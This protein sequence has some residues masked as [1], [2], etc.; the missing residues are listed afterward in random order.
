[1]P[2]ARRLRAGPDAAGRAHA[3]DRRRRALGGRRRRRGRSLVTEPG[4]QGVGHARRAVDDVAP[5]ARRSAGDQRRTGQHR[6]DP[7]AG[8]PATRGP[9]PVASCV[10]PLRPP[11]LSGRS[12]PDQ[13]PPAADPARRGGGRRRRAGWPTQAGHRQEQGDQH[14][15][16]H[17]HDDRPPAP[18]AVGLAGIEPATSSLSGMRSNRLSYS[19]AVVRSSRRSERHPTTRPMARAPDAASQ[20]STA[21]PGPAHLRGGAAGRRVS[22]STT[23]SRMPPTRSL[24]RLNTTASSTERTVTTTTRPS[25]PSTASTED[26]LAVEREALQGEG[27]ADDLLDVGDHADVHGH[28]PDHDAGERE[29]HEHAQVQEQRHL[30]HRPG[31]RRDARSAP[32]VVPACGERRGR[33]RH[34]GR[35]AGAVG[36]ATTRRSSTTATARGG[37]GWG[38]ASA[39]AGSSRASA[40]RRSTPAGAPTTTATPTAASK[41]GKDR[42][43][44][45]STHPAP[46]DPTTVGACTRQTTRSRWTCSDSGA[47]RAGGRRRPRTARRWRSPGVRPAP[48]PPAPD[49][50]PGGTP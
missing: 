32:P 23:V 18:R 22:S 34:P 1:M 13:R 36:S 31:H 26:P 41:R 43:A 45:T 39:G 35:P 7:R 12:G 2:A 50:R 15:S 9:P 44:S 8:A 3:Q 5:M 46:R 20:V 11:P 6:R 38:A 10:G 4:G 19:P 40:S 42:S 28:R 49:D 14:P 30:E 48:P 27:R 47:A 25:P 29:H 33:S 16:E 24:I 21:K 37:L 17:G